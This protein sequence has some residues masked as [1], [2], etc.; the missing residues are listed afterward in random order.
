MVKNNETARFA[1]LG[2]LVEGSRGEVNDLGQAVSLADDVVEFFDLKHVLDDGAAV[3]VVLI[4]NIRAELVDQFGN[5]ELL[6]G[7]DFSHDLWLE[8]TIN[9][10]Q[11]LVENLRDGFLVDVL[12]HLLDDVGAWSENVWNE[13]LL[14][15]ADEQRDELAE[16]S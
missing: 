8:I 1:R 16:V 11:K 10:S 2:A 15:S 14:L 6:L 9:L 7:L 4:G 13:A 5:G 12:E 3:Q